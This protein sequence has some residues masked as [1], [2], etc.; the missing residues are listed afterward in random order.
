[1]IKASHF[2][3]SKLNKLIALKWGCYCS[4]S[5]AINVSSIDS[6]TSAVA[7]HP[8]IDLAGDQILDPLHYLTTLSH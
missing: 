7:I 6:H 3:S 1:M 5:Q 8:S 4:L 2:R